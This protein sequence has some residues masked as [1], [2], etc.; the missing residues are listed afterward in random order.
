MGQRIFVCSKCDQSVQ[1][2]EAAM[3][4]PQPCVSGDHDW[5]EVERDAEEND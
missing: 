1:G 2:F 4:L 3:S 5:K